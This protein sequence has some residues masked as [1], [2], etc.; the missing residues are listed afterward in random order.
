LYHHKNIV[1]VAGLIPLFVIFCIC[2]YAQPSLWGNLKNGKY[3]VGFKAIYDY[4]Y[5]RPAIHEQSLK[6]QVVSMPSA[7]ARQMQISVWYPSER[8]GAGMK[9]QEYV[10]EM[11][12]ELDFTE[13]DLLRKDRVIEKVV[14]LFQDYQQN[15]TFT[16][17]SL[18]KLLD[19]PMYA[20]RNADAANGKFPVVIYPHWFSPMDGSIMGEYLASHGFV[21]AA[22]NMKGTDSTLPETSPRGMRS[23]TAD[24]NF[25]VNKLSELN[26][27]DVSKLA[28]MGV[29]FN[30]T[31]ALAAMK[32]NSTIDAF[33]S[34]DG[35]IV[36]DSELQMFRESGDVQLATLNKPM[37]FINTPHP[38]I[39]P[40]LSSYF[41]YA[42]KY[43]IRF[44]AMS[45]YYFLNNG[46]I[47][48]ILPGIIGKPPGDVKTGYEWA[49]R[50]VLNFLSYVLKEHLKSKQFL[51]NDT[52]D[53]GI[54]PGIVEPAFV[55]AVG[56]GMDYQ[57]L[58]SLC[59]D[60]GASALRQ[61]FDS[62][63][64]TDPQPLSTSVMADLFN[65]LGFGRDEDFSIRH[66]LIRI[67]LESYPAS[68]R[69]NYVKGRIM[70]IEKKY[71]E[72]KVFYEK[73]LVLLPD[74]YDPYLNS[75]IRHR[76]KTVSTQELT[77]H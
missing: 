69:G 51:T 5:S 76:I 75:V 7:P 49:S 68:A 77:N 55:P 42:D 20:T 33:I 54:P 73:A 1:K 14:S 48:S 59:V 60:G 9:Y 3:N 37:M 25:T 34:L 11:A 16:K 23:Q 57:H 66:E 35:G 52:V 58:K 72:A 17:E 50:Y 71:D 22:I 15:Q 47:E 41:K 29:G 39:K 6:G 18:Q 8:K 46:M 65:W 4:D 32:D 74:D 26:F 24:I 61:W 53:N 21:V 62:I 63:K 67:W 28:V 36:T 64:A 12:K 44:P 70:T 19:Q 45:E 13:P 56:K 2:S 43:L 38:S 30:G 27:C 10:L 40:E 31:A